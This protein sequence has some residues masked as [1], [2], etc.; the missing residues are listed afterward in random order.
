MPTTIRIIHSGD[1]VKA[2][3]EGTLDLEESRRILFEVAAQFPPVNDYHI[4]IDTRHAHSAMSITDLWYL[5][6]ELKHGLQLRNKIAVL[7][8]LERFQA[9]EFLEL[10]AQN[11]G[12]N[13]V[14]FTLFEEA[15]NW[16][17]DIES[18]PVS[19]NS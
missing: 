7:C 15:I 2:T 5:A 16:L 9:A 8:P 12:L 1:F 13:V 17:C 19:A 10:C 4:L 11:R 18:G 14:A 6:S 3:A